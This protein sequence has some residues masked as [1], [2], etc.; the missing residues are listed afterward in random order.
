[1]QDRSQETRE[2]PGHIV[3]KALTVYFDVTH[4]TMYQVS[5]ATALVEGIYRGAVRIGVLREHGDLG[6]G[7]LGDLDGETVIVG[8]HR[9]HLLKAGGGWQDM[10]RPK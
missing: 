3:N 9:W 7:T 6:L 8:G 5:T 2:P 10:R 1:L 4:H